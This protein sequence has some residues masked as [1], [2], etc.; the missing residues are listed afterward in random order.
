M[1]YTF[2]ANMDAFGDTVMFTGVEENQTVLVDPALSIANSMGI[3][4]EKA[5][6][7]IDQ[8]TFHVQAPD[9][10]PA[11]SPSDP[12]PINGA[13]GTGLRSSS[14]KGEQNNSSGSGNKRDSFSGMPKS[15]SMVGPPF[16]GP[17]SGVSCSCVQQLVWLLYQLDELTHTPGKPVTSTLHHGTPSMG[18]VLRNV[19][20]A[21]ELWARLRGCAAHGTEESLQVNLLFAMSIRSLLSSVSMLISTINAASSVSSIAVSIGN[22]ELAG[23]GK[24]DIISLAIRQSLRAIIVALRQLW[25]RI[26]RPP[27]SST[28]NSTGDNTMNLD[29][30]STNAGALLKPLKAGDSPPAVMFAEEAESA[31]SLQDTVKQCIQTIERKSAPFS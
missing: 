11:S 21:E 24:V 8:H 4:T 16:V 29:E 19:K 1:P 7:S 17:G 28:P 22:F 9:D 2:D 13:V 20:A 18:P 14:V 31:A 15:S 12:S 5:N 26:G 3:G 27:T 25:D 23:E 10:M 6:P 30:S